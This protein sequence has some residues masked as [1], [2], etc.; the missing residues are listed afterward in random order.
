MTEPEAINLWQSW[1]QQIEKRQYFR[2]P[3]DTPETTRLA[4][5]GTMVPM[6]EI[7]YL[8]SEKSSLLPLITA[9]NQL[10]PI[11]RAAVGF[12]TTND[13]LSFGSNGS[14]WSGYWSSHKSSGWF[15][16]SLSSALGKLPKSPGVVY[17]GVKID[18]PFVEKFIS[19]LFSTGTYVSRGFLSTSINA[20]TN[21]T[22]NRPLI[23]IIHGRSGVDVAPFSNYGF[24]KEI[25]FPPGCEFKV[26]SIEKRPFAGAGEKIVVTLEEI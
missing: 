13:P 22:R 7:E 4:K 2:R 23:L 5:L 24:E 6:Q 14:L 11:E 25:L 15:I 3:F 17:S 16:K 1:H 18:T 10:Q 20:E 21:Y 8:S 9:F 19:N 26:L 12:Y